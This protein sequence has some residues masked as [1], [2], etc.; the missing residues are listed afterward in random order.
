MTGLRRSL[1]LLAVLS[2]LSLPAQAAPF[3]DEVSDLFNE[4]VELLKQGK[5]EAALEKF[6]AV[7]AMQ[8]DHEAAYELWKDTDDDIWVDMLVR[9][10][11]Y[12]LVAKRFLDL[13]SI[14]HGQRA[15]DPDAIRELIRQLQGEDVLERRRAQRTLAANHGEYAVPHMIHHLA[16]TVNE[17]RR[18]VVMHALTEM[19]RSVVLPLLAALHTDDAYL[20]RNIC[21][22]LGYLG[23][24]R[25]GAA[26]SF[27]SAHDSDEGVRMAAKEGAMKVGASGDALPLFLQLGADYHR[28]AA[29]VLNPGDWSDVVWS[30]KD[31][32]LAKTEV[33]RYLYADELAKQSYLHALM[34]DPSSLDARAGL[35]RAYVSQLG[36]LEMR[37]AA[38][39][40]VEGSEGLAESALA[41]NSSGV[42]A[43]DLALQ[44]S[45]A[46]RDASTAGQLLR[47]LG[48][49]AGQPTPGMNA[50][51][52]QGDGAIRSEA[53]VALGHLA[54]ANNQA[55]SSD[56]VA[57]LAEA[58]GREVV[59]IAMVIDSDTGRGNAM[60]GALEGAGFMAIAMDRGT[61]AL[62]TLHQVPG[63][64]V[65]VVADSLNDLT[66]AQVVDD[67]RR[68]EL[69]A[70]TPILLMGSDEAAEAYGDTIN[71]TVAAGDVAAVEAVV[72]DGMNQDRERA[73]ALAADAASVLEMLARG[74]GKT[75][76]SGV[77]PAL[78]GTL[79]AERPDDVTIPA[80]GCLGAVAGTD[81]VGPLMG[82]LTSDERSDEARV[83][84][85]GAIGQIATRSGMTADGAALNSLVDVMQSDASLSVRSAAAAAAGRMRLDAEQRAQLAAA[86]RV[87][88]SE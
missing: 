23:D 79:A 31:G 46:D 71:G 56:A 32:E 8:P 63:M 44:W 4:G 37:A 48:H 76:L 75:N 29:N 30:W 45:V 67:I 87:M 74:A 24:P 40:D 70:A 52:G 59:R 28:R 6:T 17:D 26:L 88:L 33:A 25:A 39:A 47:A 20:R 86:T 57:A 49:L 35:A 69:L 51:L 2:A 5:E 62:H 9:G 77:E 82:V 78:L 16:D 1:G 36:E 50:A 65:I 72:A 13:A 22:V 10:G 83:A 55:A 73:N 64:D 80:M 68:S 27:L 54:Y 60:A 66:T 19:D 84:A 12:E 81:A 34:V 11:Q 15:D 58:A 43:L 42:D 85:A 18:V 21:L 3:V 61:A 38:G 53:A 14:Q 7:L 41:V